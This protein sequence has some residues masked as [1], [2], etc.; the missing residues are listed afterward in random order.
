MKEEMEEEPNRTNV[1]GGQLR[2]LLGGVGRLECNRREE[3]CAGMRPQ[4]FD[5]AGL[6]KLSPEEIKIGFG[7]FSLSGECPSRGAIRSARTL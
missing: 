1:E 3:S 6:D 4:R 2:R 5:D 7:W